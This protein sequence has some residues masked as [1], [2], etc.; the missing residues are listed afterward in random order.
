M[1]RHSRPGIRRDPSCSCSFT[2]VKR[3]PGQQ[4]SLCREAGALQHCDSCC[5]E[6]WGHLRSCHLTTA[7]LDGFWPSYVSLCAVNPVETE[8]GG[9]GQCVAASTPHEYSNCKLL[10]LFLS[11]SRGKLLSPPPPLHPFLLLILIR[12]SRVSNSRLS[13][14]KMITQLQRRE[15]R[16]AAG[17]EYRLKVK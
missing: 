2:W 13:W 15:E 12:Y 7:T 14:W 17:I 8:K 10:Q 9:G 5:W 6:G 3:G 11:S 1:I 4:D 16:T